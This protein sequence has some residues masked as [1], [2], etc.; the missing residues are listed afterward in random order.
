V[1]GLKVGAVRADHACMRTFG[2]IVVGYF[3]LSF[4]ATGLVFSRQDPAGLLVLGGAAGAF[5][6]LVRSYRGGQHAETIRRDDAAHVETA[7]RRL[8]AHAE[9]L[10]ARLPADPLELPWMVA[11]EYAHRDDAGQRERLEQAYHLVRARTLE[12]RTE[13]DR[14][15]S[16]R[17]SGPTYAPTIIADYERLGHTLA[18]LDAAASAL[19]TRGEAEATYSD[20]ATSGESPPPTES[21]SEKEP[22]AAERSADPVTEAAERAKSAR[23][24]AWAWVLAAPDIDPA[25]SALVEEAESAYQEALA[26]QA[27]S[28]V[29]DAVGGDAGAD[30]CAAFAR[31][32]RLADVARAK[33]TDRGPRRTT[34]AGDLPWG[35]AAGAAAGVHVD[36][37]SDG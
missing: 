27:T 6:W 23:D 33:A 11:L 5:V 12:C 20:V 22:P 30:A 16:D 4:M 21:A 10:V 28:A 7:E 8:R 1:R 13:L 18:D 9:A 24:E 31:A 15:S 35:P 3:L 25:A 34:R 2:Y 29:G 37:T 26:V 17:Q 14:F 36:G 32:E 19:Q